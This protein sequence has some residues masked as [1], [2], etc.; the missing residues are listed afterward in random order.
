[1][2]NA[3]NVVLTIIALSVAGFMVTQLG[4]AFG[5]IA[6]LLS[7]LSSVFLVDKIRESVD[8]LSLRRR[9]ENVYVVSCHPVT[10]EQAEVGPDLDKVIFWA[11]FRQTYKTAR[12]YERWLEESGNRF[13]GPDVPDRYRLKVV[14]IIFQDGANVNETFEEFADRVVAE[15]REDRSIRLS[16]LRDQ[17]PLRFQKY[18]NR[19]VGV[20]L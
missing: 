11:S 6:F 19:Q 16:A 1:M 12:K 13:V 10:K 20:R 2:K 17:D 4:L 7:S 9:L 14:P 15:I 18:A 3:F 5:G 8:R